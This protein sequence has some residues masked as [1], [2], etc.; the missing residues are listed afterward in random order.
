[1]VEDETKEDSKTEQKEVPKSTL[2]F[3]VPKIPFNQ[4]LKKQKDEE[5]FS[6]F[7]KIFKKLQINVPFLK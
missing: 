2:P 5:Q 6:K 4:R 7:L 1:M 3:F